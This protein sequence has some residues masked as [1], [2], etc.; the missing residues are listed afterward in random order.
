MIFKTFDGDESVR[1]DGEALDVTSLH[2]CWSGIP[3]MPSVPLEEP[4]NRHNIVRQGCFD[5]HVNEWQL[6]RFATAVMACIAPE[7]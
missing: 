3:A 5:S 4:A 2:I 1:T 7:P 6:S